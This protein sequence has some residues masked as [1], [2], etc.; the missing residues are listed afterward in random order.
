MNILFYRYGS[1]CEP[2]VLVVFQKMGFI[3]HQ[4]DL[5]ISQK[6]LTTEQRLNAVASILCEH[7]IHFVFSI[8][9]YPLLSE[10]CEKLGLLYVCWSVDCPVLELFSN[11][12]R[13]SCNRIFLFDYNQY[14]S[15]HPQ[16]PENV[17]YLPLATN[18]NRWDEVLQNLTEK[19]IQKYSSDISFVGSL[20]HE[21]SPLSLL[22]DTSP[23]PDF[24]TGYVNGLCES[25]AK[26]YGY[27]FLEDAI[28]D[29]FIAVLKQHFPKFLR[30]EN[31]FTDTDSFVAANYYLG[32][33][34]S[35]LERIRVLNELATAHKVTLYTR[36]NTR[37]LQNV[38]CREG[39]S[40]HTE[41][42]KI[43]RCSKINL[44][45]TI[46][47][48][49][50]GLSLRVWDVLG[51]GGFLLSNYQSEIPEYLEIGK[52]LDCYE[53]L[54]DLKQ[55]AAFYLKN[56]DL[57]NE[58]ARNGYDK[59]RQFHTYEARIGSMLKTIFT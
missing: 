15:I 13:N 38:D 25:Q 21:K 30:L 52:D 40:T 46:K 39:V 3:V 55:K 47:S 11:S 27:N 54:A 4:C 8:N 16:N 6:N 42:P 34:T 44:N 51:C 57:R 9:F 36:S 22:K 59:V 41:M 5:E 2:D 1:I 10:V 29:E 56:D 53:S 43:F 58:I 31:S 48:I 28:S 19:D 23:L 35:E 24:W 32:I 37:L 18:V 14:L 12:V 26:V 20:Y 33:R 49:Q 7:P 17:F 50:S 45:I